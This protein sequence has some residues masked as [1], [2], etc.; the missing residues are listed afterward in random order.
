MPYGKRQTDKEQACTNKWT[1]LADSVF[2]ADRAKE[3]HVV[4]FYTDDMF[5]REC[6]CEFVRSAIADSDS[7]IVIASKKH[8]DGLAQRL[9]LRGVDVKEAVKQGRYLV[10]DTQTALSKFMDGKLPDKKRFNALFNLRIE[11]ALVASGS[12]HRRVAIFGE[13]VAVLGA[14]HNFDGAL[15]LEHLWNELAA[16]QPFHLRCAYPAKAFQGKQDSEAYAAVCA[17][18][19]AVISA[20]PT[21]NT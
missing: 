20:E 13:M 7:A 19:S 12:S 6:I 16:S 15:R 21:F 9:Q 11:R 2:E 4:Q 17:H 10:F 3:E 1:D 5:L 8:R 18:H 14:E